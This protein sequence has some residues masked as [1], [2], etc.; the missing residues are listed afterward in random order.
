MILHRKELGEIL[1]A[2]QCF[3]GATL[4]HSNTFRLLFA[5]TVAD[6]NFL[7]DHPLISFFQD[8]LPPRRRFLCFPWSPAEMKEEW[9]QVLSRLEKPCSHTFAKEATSVCAGCRNM[10]YCS[11]ECQVCH[12][13]TQSSNDVLR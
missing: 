6:S 11:K 3:P 10:R 4:Y 9:K 12:T 5:S 13:P 1:L 8:V 2:R 7:V